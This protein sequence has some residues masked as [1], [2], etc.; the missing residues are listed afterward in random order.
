[1]RTVNQLFTDK[2][3]SITAEINVLLE[4]D[5]PLVPHN[6]AYYIIRAN[7]LWHKINGN[8][9]EHNLKHVDIDL[10]FIK[11]GLIKEYRP[12]MK[13]GSFVSKNPIMNLEYERDFYI[14]NDSL[15][16]ARRKEIIDYIHTYNRT[17]LYRYTEGLFFRT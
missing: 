5:K 17:H 16:I 1:M 3:N 11:Y 7:V 10:Y 13:L 2:V 14:E 9:S 8:I 4:F 6:E 15:R 12:I